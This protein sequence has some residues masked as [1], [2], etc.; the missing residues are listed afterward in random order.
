MDIAFLEDG[1]VEF[2]ITRAGID[3]R[4]VISKP[5]KYGVDK[6]R[7][8]RNGGIGDVR[9]EGCKMSSTPFGITI[10]FYE[11]E[12]PGTYQWVR[13]VDGMFEMGIELERGN[14][15]RYGKSCIRIPLLEAQDAIDKMIENFEN[16]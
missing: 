8:I 10:I 2:I 11:S 9:Y 16:V 13:L 12:K 1:G 3:T 14:N 5:F 6:W 15:Q 7:F 4:F